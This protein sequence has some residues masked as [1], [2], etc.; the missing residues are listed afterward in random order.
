MRTS[1]KEIMVQQHIGVRPVIMGKFC[2]SCSH[3]VRFEL[4]YTSHNNTRHY[5]KSCYSAKEKV[6]DD[7]FANNLTAHDI[8][9]RNERAKVRSI[10]HDIIHDI[11]SLP[12]GEVSPS[13]HTIVM[14]HSIGASLNGEVH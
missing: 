13:V 3:L 10:L 14:K 2:Q 1:P 5:C 12:D 4:M 9:L 11:G 8:W 7:V 6:Y